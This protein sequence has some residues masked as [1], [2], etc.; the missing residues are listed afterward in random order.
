MIVG[1]CTVRIMLRTVN[2]LKEKRS[3]VKSIIDKIKRKYNVSIAET[4]L[5]DIWKSTELGIAYV[6]NN[7]VH[8]NSVIHSIIEYL[9]DECMLEVI[10]FNIEIL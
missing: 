3:I 2:S 7:S 5:N 1:T 8:A 9:E 4:D 10:N 6:S